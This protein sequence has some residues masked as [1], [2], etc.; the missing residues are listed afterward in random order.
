MSKVLDGQTDIFG[1]FGLFDEEGEKKRQEAEARQAQLKAK[2]EAAKQNAVAN[3]K[4]KEKVVPFEVNQDT[5]LYYYGQTYP[6]ADYFDVEEL[7]EG[8][9]TV[10][11]DGE[12]SVRVKMT[13]EDI[14][15]GLEKTFYNLVKDY[16]ELI[17]MK[18]KNMVV[19]MSKAKKKG[20]TTET[21][22]FKE[23]EANHYDSLSFF[24]S[25]GC[26]IPFHVLQEFLHV[27]KMMGECNLEV[28]G[29]IYVNPQTLEF[30][31]DFPKQS[32]H[33]FWVKVTEESWETVNRMF[34]LI[35][36][37]EIHS[38]HE[39]APIPSPTDNQNECNPGMLYLIVG[40]IER[41]FPS[42]TA[43]TFDYHTREH[44]VIN[45]NEIL[46][47]MT[48]TVDF[49]SQFDMNKIEVNQG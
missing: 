23:D 1:D 14:R 18:E 45:L 47:D 7:E 9:L 33:E 32:C 25:K 48:S 44:L 49:P 27:A 13:E 10:Q 34:P 30:T 19:V 16:T 36:V 5:T 42:I 12:E 31:V 26:K 46:G 37:A 6:L 8:I 4:S 29:D 2:M 20:N 22:N 41:Y 11:K 38:H 3:T 17:Y 28:H 24:K 40:H 43:R 39:M 15:K 35:K 21:E